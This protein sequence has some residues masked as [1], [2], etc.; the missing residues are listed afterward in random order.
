MLYLV[1]FIVF[2]VF[3][4]VYFYNRLV[5]LKQNVTEAWSDIDVQLK[6]RYELIPN[7]VNTVK[8][9]ATHEKNLFTQIAELRTKA[10]SLN[11]NDIKGK[12]GVETE[13]EKSLK[14]IL[15][16][17]ESYPDLKASANYLKLQETLSETEDQ[18][19]SARRIY[20]S[21]AADYN[22]LVLSF[23]ANLLAGL[24]GFGQCS[25]FQSEK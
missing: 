11:P 12:S 10:L 5:S 3:L 15:A 6:R 23:P 25:F 19:A 14:S 22:T 21:N 24:F 1:L 8:G 20:N 7:L 9:Y 18:I 2:I 4:A 16:I 17:A 13:I